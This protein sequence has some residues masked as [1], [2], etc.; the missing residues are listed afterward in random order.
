MQYRPG[1]VTENP[2]VIFIGPCMQ[3]MRHHLILTRGLH[4][5]GTMVL[6]LVVRDSTFCPAFRR[7][8]SM[9]K[10]IQDS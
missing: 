4:G 5:L 2:I 9:K 8:M 6:V 3:D 10:G 1:A 7:C